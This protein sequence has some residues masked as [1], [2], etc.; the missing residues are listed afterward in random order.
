MLYVSGSKLQPGE[1]SNHF[2]WLISVCLS[3][4]DSRLITG[5]TPTHLI[6]H[7]KFILRRYTKSLLEG[8]YLYHGL[9]YTPDLRAKTRSRAG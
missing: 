7:N 8:L 2:F 6:T 3:T 9:L 4:T 1:L 5:A